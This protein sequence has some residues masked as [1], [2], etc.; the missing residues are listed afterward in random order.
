VEGLGIMVY[1]PSKQVSSEL[2]ASN[3]TTGRFG[4]G[5]EEPEGGGEEV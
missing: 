3:I 4:M 2:D 5:E 1:Q